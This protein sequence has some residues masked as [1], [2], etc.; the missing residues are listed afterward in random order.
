MK[1]AKTEHT[2]ESFKWIRHLGDVAG[3]ERNVAEL[4]CNRQVEQS[5]LLA[6]SL[7][8]PLGAL[9]AIPASNC[10]LRA[11]AAE[12]GHKIPCFDGSTHIT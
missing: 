8:I 5:D 4:K 12:K 1:V 2:G 7:C 6:G 3:I 10:T 9:S 11:P